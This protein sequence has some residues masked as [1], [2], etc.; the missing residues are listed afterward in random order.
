MS[1]LCVRKNL[2]KIR[3]FKQVGT[4]FFFFFFFGVFFFFQSVSSIHFNLFHQYITICFIN[5]FQSVSS[6]HFNL[7]HQSIS[8]C[9]R[10]QALA[11]FSR[12]FVI[13]FSPFR[14]LFLALFACIWLA[15]SWFIRTNS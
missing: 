13:F 11:L 5:T 8:I 15:L 9:V 7:V 4:I 1:T 10:F 12:T 2:R 6:I 14:F 3:N